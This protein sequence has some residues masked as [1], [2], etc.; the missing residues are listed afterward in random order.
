MTTLVEV[1]NDASG[2]DEQTADKIREVLDDQLTVPEEIELKDSQPAI[3]SG[4]TG[5]WIV[6]EFEVTPNRSGEIYALE[7]AHTLQVYDGEGFLEP[8]TS[9]E[10]ISQQLADI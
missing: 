4:D 8:T 1:L 5:D 10:H 9:V 2:I 6:A 7:H 3:A